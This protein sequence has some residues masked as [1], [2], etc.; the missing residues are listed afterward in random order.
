MRQTT[1]LNKKFNNGQFNAD[2]N[3]PSG[4]SSSLEF[5]IQLSTNEEIENYESK[6]SNPAPAVITT[7]STNFHE[8]ISAGYGTWHY[9]IEKLEFKAGLREIGRAHV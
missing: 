1:Q 3:T 6:K 5:G 7:Q 8:I 9:K 2:Y 4:K